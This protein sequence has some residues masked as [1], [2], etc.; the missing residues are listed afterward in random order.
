MAKK[1]IRELDTI[2]AEGISPLEDFFPLSKVGKDY[3]ISIAELSAFFKKIPDDFDTTGA[4]IEVG[5]NDPTLDNLVN[6]RV[7]IV[8]SEERTPILVYLDFSANEGEL[9]YL[10]I[11]IFIEISNISSGLMITV[12]CGNLPLFSKAYSP[13][14]IA[15]FITPFLNG[16]YFIKDGIPQKI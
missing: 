14:E 10:D 2:T 5:D 12:F 7:G 13:G 15:S 4:Q 6:K 11:Y 16:W 3:K 1:T 8:F 9:I